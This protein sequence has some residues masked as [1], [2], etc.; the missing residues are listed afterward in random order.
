MPLSEKSLELIVSGMP[1][2]RRIELSESENVSREFLI[3]GRVLLHS[4]ICHTICT[5]CQSYGLNNDGLRNQIL[6]ITINIIK[7]ILIIKMLII[8]IIITTLILP[9]CPPFYTGWKKGE[10]F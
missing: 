7:S 1:Y 9:P 4:I 3:P 6:K 8:I 10:S 2:L 5:I